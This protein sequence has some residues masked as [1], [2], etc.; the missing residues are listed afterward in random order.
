MTSQI[1]MFFSKLFKRCSLRPSIHPVGRVPG[2]LPARESKSALLSFYVETVAQGGAG[3][4][5]AC[6][7]K[8]FQDCGQLSPGNDTLTRRKATLGYHIMFATAV[9]GCLWLA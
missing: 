9:T 6:E 5:Q 7:S 1:P 8:R 2:S 3:S 4:G